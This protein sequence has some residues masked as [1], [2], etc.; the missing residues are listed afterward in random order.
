MRAHGE[1]RE[2]VGMLRREQIARSGM[3]DRS[4]SQQI[5]DAATVE[6]EDDGCHLSAAGPQSEKGVMG[7]IPML[8]AT[9][10]MV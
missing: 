2:L 3:R 7:H 4:A 10:G 8:L 5:R 9:R 6:R 1:W